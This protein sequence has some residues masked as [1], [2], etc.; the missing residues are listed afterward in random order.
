MVAVVIIAE[1][2]VGLECVAPGIGQEGYAALHY[3]LPLN[4]SLTHSLTLS[5]IVSNRA[6]S[7]TRVA[8]TSA[9]TALDHS[10]TTGQS[11]RFI[12]SSSS[13]FFSI[14]LFSLQTTRTSHAVCKPFPF[15]AI[16]WLG[17]VGG[18][19]NRPSS[20]PSRALGIVVLSKVD[21]MRFAELA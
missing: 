8:L 4:R 2:K 10:D 6:D 18:S 15:N 21:L 5:M 19:R 3:G 13:F 1:E 14:S 11:L 7:K 16:D 12:H 9:I 17:F 20:S